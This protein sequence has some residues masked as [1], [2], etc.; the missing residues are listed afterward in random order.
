MSEK[1]LVNT[2]RE[3]FERLL[4]G[5]PAQPVDIGTSEDADVVSLAG[6]LNRFI[7]E[8]N[9]VRE[10]SSALASG[11]LEESPLPRNLLA[12][13]FKQ[14]HAA[15]RHLTWQTERIAKGDY[16]Q[17][18]HFMGDFSNAFNSMVETLAMSEAQ[19]QSANEELRVQ[20]EELQAQGEELQAQN[21]ELD[22]QNG[23]LAQLWEKTVQAEQS[24]QKANEGLE[25]QVRQRTSEL[26]QK[27][28]ILIQQNRMA[29]LGEMFEHIAHQWQQPLNN[30]AIIV[31]VLGSTSA[32]EQVTNKEI[33]ETV[34]I[35]MDMV[36]HMVQT[37]DVFRNFYKPDK[38][39]SAF[40]IKESIEKALSFVKPA[41]RLYG[42]EVDLD[43][44]SELSAFGYPKEY[45]QVLLNI[46]GNAKDAFI[47]RSV[48]NP[49]ISIKA[50]AD[51]DNTVVTIT[52]NAGG[53]PDG[54]LE[55]IFDLYFTT[56]ESS[57][58]TGIGLYMS[59]NIIVKNM[60]GKLS[61]R[62]SDNGAQFR[63][64]LT[65]PDVFPISSFSQRREISRIL[66]AA[67]ALSGVNP[68]TI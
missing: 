11:N 31:Q 68:L 57:G 8:Y 17:R 38:E 43:A 60:G 24:L 37:V 55:R 40:L 4:I 12:S 39:K 47:E 50:L 22:A 56:K 19:L 29:A 36:G 54:S 52:D 28:I 35:V 44:N 58:G 63:I 2:L 48:E 41:L 13:P 6:T 16:S 61:V 9:A 25:I 49:R 30:I 46:L 33:L 34:D 10:F 42:I 26:R 15:L 23:E 1:K 62:N 59:R 53:I 20:G 7:T 21:E 64:E 51:G 3:Q 18:V 14:L 67:P 32:H 45:A 5:E 65:N 66:S 27:D